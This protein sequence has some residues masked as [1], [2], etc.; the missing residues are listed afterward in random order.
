MRCTDLIHAA[1]N[2]GFERLGELGRDVG[3]EDGSGGVA[4]GQDLPDSLLFC[5]TVNGGKGWIG[6]C[7]ERFAGQILDRFIDLRQGK[8]L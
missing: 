6:L 5:N 3:L 4:A 1:G 8:R 7:A 2:D